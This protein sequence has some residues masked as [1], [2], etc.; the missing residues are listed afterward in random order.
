M[1]CLR[2]SFFLKYSQ[3]RKETE[4]MNLQWNVF[5]GG[6]PCSNASIP[7][8]SDDIF[9]LRKKSIEMIVV[10][11]KVSSIALNDHWVWNVDQLPWK[12]TYSS[13]LIAICFLSLV[14]LTKTWGEKYVHMGTGRSK[15]FAALLF[16]YPSWAWGYS[17]VRTKSNA[18]LGPRCQQSWVGW[19]K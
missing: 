2:E 4:G 6:T 15:S 9:P 17:R 12:R 16:C 7:C 13:L 18:F 5:D 3:H 8:Q 19:L 10:V 14:L 11:P 1:C